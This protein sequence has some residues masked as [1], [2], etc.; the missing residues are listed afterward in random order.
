MRVS[1]R[2]QWYSKF[3][4]QEGSWVLVILL[5]ISHS[6]GNGEVQCNTT[7]TVDRSPKRRTME[8]DWAVLF[9]NKEMKV[10]CKLVLKQPM[11]MWLWMPS[12]FLLGT[13]PLS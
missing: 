8:L 7:V 2:I 10:T 13:P 5:N 6:L 12:D 4:N 9:L 3:K 11:V 1:K